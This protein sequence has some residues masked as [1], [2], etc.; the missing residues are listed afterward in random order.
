MVLNNLDAGRKWTVYFSSKVHMVIRGIS[1]YPFYRY[2]RV[3]AGALKN[4]LFLNC[5]LNNTTLYD[6]SYV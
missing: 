5:L 4:S 1:C 3:E 2:F 6:V